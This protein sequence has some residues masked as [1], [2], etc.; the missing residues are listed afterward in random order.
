[1]LALRDQYVERFGAIP[2]V[3]LCTAHDGE[4]RDGEV[5]RL[6]GAKTPGVYVACMGLVED[7]ELGN[8]GV[9]QATLA[10]V[11]FVLTRSPDA[12]REVRRSS[13]DVAALIALAIV[14]ELVR[15]EHFEAAWSPA[16]ALRCQNLFGTSSAKK[17][18][19]LWAVTWHQSTEITPEGLEAVLNPFRTFHTDVDV[20]QDGNVDMSGTKT[21][22]IDRDMTGSAEGDSTATG[23]LE[24]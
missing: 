12:V 7:D 11:A 24:S 16:T 1:M 4:F 2:A 14:H 17:G 18:H 19:T 3:E 10:W 5:E 6:G 13:G 15:G 22:P 20:D 23:D 9:L 8:A 21:L